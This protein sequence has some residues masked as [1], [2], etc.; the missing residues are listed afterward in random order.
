MLLLIPFS[1][2]YLFLFFHS[3]ILSFYR[4]LYNLYPNPILLDI[5][6]NYI[7]T[8]PKVTTLLTYIP[9]SCLIFF[10]HFYL[11]LLYFLFSFIH[12]YLLYLS[13]MHFH[14]SFLLFL[15]IVLLCLN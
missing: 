8:I 15:H 13:F 4:V 5:L 11:S 6:S 2:L 9:T 1:F 10:T 12:F 7:Y 14:L 3:F